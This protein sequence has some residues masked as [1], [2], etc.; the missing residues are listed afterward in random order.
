MADRDREIIDFEEPL[1]DEESEFH[2]SEYLTI[3]RKRT[4]LIVLCVLLALSVTVVKSLMSKPLYRATTV[5]DIDKDR[6]TPYDVSDRLVLYSWWD[7]EYLPTQTRLVRSREVAERV[8]RKLNLLQNRDFNPAAE[9]MS[10]E[11]VIA[12][13]DKRVTS[14]ALGVQGGITVSPVKGTNLVELSYVAAS[15]ELAADIA[16]AVAE[17]YIDWN[18]ETKYSTLDK[19]TRFITSQIEQLKAEIRDKELQLQTY[20]REKGIVSPDPQMNVTLQNLDQLN[21]DYAA[22]VADRVAKQARFAEYQDSKPEALAETLSSATTNARAELSRLEREYAE[23]QTLFKEDYPAMVQLR[24]QLDKARQEYDKLVDET[25]TRARELA[26]TEYYTALRR[27]RALQDVLQGQKTAAMDLNSNAIEYNNI[28]VEVETKRQL[29]DGLLKRQNETEMTSRLQSERVSNIRIVDRALPPGGPFVPNHSKNAAMGLFLGLFAGVGLA[30][31]LEYMDRSIRSVKQVEQYLKLPALGLI[32]AIGESG[33]GGYAYGYYSLARRRKQTSGEIPKAKPATGSGPVTIELIPHTKPRSTVAEAY[34]AIRTALLLS[35][36]GGVRS[37]VV[38]SS[39][40]GEGKTSTSANLAVVLAQLKK[41]VLLVDA[42]LHKPRMHEIFRVSNR[43]GLVSVLAENV[44]PADVIVGTA[45]PD[46]SVLPAGPLSPNPSGLLASEAMTAFLEY[47]ATH[48]DFVVIDSPPVSAV[49]DA[50]VMG[51]QVDGVVMG[52]EGGRTPR[53]IV[54]RV[55]DKLVRANVRILGV[56]INNL[57][58]QS[59]DYGYYYH[60]YTGTYGAES[61]YTER[62]EG[63][64]T[65]SRGA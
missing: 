13:A 32:P 39:L 7:P 19:A 28:Y 65:R 29:L 5:L 23:K 55:R 34:R 20:G 17:T 35:R 38:T 48:F 36:A 57:A 27:E 6:G 30:F 47:A 9:Q 64:G 45:V 54:A 16:N 11:E 49:A 43:T 33:M 10:P 46:L 3:L 62:V 25:V 41:K 58:E 44:E 61:G 42:D 24:A 4:R 63:T 12:D 51:N 31:L 2:I 56:L 15:P 37:M 26:R 60:Y 14:A 50:I 52:V 22:A 21:K 1:D 53:E 18:L 8:V 59:F 40:P